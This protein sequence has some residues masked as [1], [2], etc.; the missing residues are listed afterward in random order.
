MRF[1]SYESKFSQLLLKLCYSCYLNVLWFVCSIPIVTIGASTTALYYVSLKIVREEEESLTQQFFHAFKE[2]FKQS[3][4]LWLILLLA[5]L[6]LGGDAFIV[7]RLRQSAAGNAGVF[8]TLILAVLIACAVIYTIVLI[9]VFP[10]VASVSNTTTAMLKNAF[11]I[12]THYLFATILVFAVHFAM[13][14]VVVAWFTPLAIFG[15]G[16]CALIS[17]WLLNNILISV[18]Y[19]PDDEGEADEAGNANAESESQKNGGSQP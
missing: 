5:G 1:F 4:I 18:S 10:L 6:F 7:T 13:F 9:Y 8:W 19:V 12:G 2:N 11:I 15:E 16:L 14:F 3:T 17:A